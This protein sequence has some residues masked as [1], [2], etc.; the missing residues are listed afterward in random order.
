MSKF[1]CKD[2]TERYIGCHSKC[3]KYIKEKEQHV[4]KMQAEN[5]HKTKVINEYDFNRPRKKHR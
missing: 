4:A 2:C 5:Q 1:S 3:E